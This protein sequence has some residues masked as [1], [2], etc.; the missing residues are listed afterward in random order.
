MTAAE[1]ND[2]TSVPTAETSGRRAPERMCIVTRKTAG[3]DD[4]VRFVAGPDGQVVPDLKGVLPGRGCYVLTDRDTLEL[5]IKRKAFQRAISAT[6]APDLPQ[7]VDRLLADRL[8]GALGLL[9]KGGRLV[10]GAAKVESDIRRNAV[11]FVL[12]AR[13]AAADGVRKITQARRALHFDG[14]DDVPA[15]CLLSSAE[16]SLALGQEN[17]IHAAATRNRQS[18]G[19]LSCAFALWCYR[20]RE[21][22]AFILAVPPN[23]AEHDDEDAPKN[24]RRKTD[25]E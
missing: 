15:F 3:K 23:S 11:T 9:R 8:L 13:D 19:A 18:A 12:H 4:L 10:L 14:G 5:A 24:R 16:M 6:P 20:G 22:D 25:Q 7:L 1:K 21:D 17:V 2:P